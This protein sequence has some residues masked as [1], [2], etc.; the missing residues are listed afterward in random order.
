VDVSDFV[1]KFVY[2]KGRGLGEA[3]HSRRNFTAAAAAFLQEIGT[4]D[5]RGIHQALDQI[6]QSLSRP[7]HTSYQTLPTSRVS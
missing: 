3:N 6:F 5:V 1:N 7:H 2:E 4:S